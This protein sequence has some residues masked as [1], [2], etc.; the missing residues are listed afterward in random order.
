MIRMLGRA[1]LVAGLLTSAV[2]LAPGTAVAGK[3]DDTLVVAFQR[4]I[5]NLDRLFTV[6]REML[7]LSQL[8]DDGLFYADPKT[9]KYI[10][11]AAKSYKYIDPTTLDVVIR[12]GVKFHNGGTLLNLQSVCGTV[13]SLLP[14]PISCRWAIPPE[15]PFS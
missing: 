14:V 11:L 7:I 10:P 5:D 4:S 12:D 9:L 6:R 2:F 13:V 1:A 3:S 15:H 8:T